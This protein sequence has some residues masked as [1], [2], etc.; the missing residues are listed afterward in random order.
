[1]DAIIAGVHLT[2]L[3]LSHF[4]CHTN[5]VKEF[6]APITLIIG[7]NGS[8]KT[9]ILEA[10]RLLSTGNSVRVGK[11]SEVIQ[12]EAELARIKSKSN[13]TEGED[14][15]LEVMITPGQVQGTKSQ[16]RILLVNGVRRLK[17][18]FAGQLLTAWFRPEDMRLMEGSPSRRREYLDEVLELT[19]REYAY[20]LAQYGQFLERRNKVLQAV[21]VGEA[22]QSSLH[23]WSQGLLTHGEVLQTHR[24]RYLQTFV[25][26]KFPLPFTIEY[27]PSVLSQARQSEYFSREIAAGHSLIGPHKDDFSVI[28][29]NRD[30]SIYGSRGQ[31][32]MAVLWLKMA[33]VA[34]IT[35][36]KNQRPVLLLDDVWSELDEVSQQALTELL[37]EGQALITTTEEGLA[38]E[39][40]FPQ[41]YEVV[42][43]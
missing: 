34:Y 29:S 36:Q 23:F 12:F 21:R 15:E 22:P 25:D 31:Q 27:V 18:N 30:I 41:Q 24:Q 32:R 2:G 40:K 20:A 39:L 9:S 7:R 33:E 43:M 13:I 4:R 35:A 28:L 11:L 5:W 38:K 26:V 3:H 10:V 6:T 42:K 16:V 17:K 1:V 19:H 37:S 8:G 14:T